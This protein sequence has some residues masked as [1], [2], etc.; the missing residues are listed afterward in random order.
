M[1][2][3]TRNN[4]SFHKT[5]LSAALLLALTSITTFAVHADQLADIKK[6]AW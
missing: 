3:A 2:M 4:R 1:I 6:A 5:R